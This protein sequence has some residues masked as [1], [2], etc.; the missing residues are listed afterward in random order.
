MIEIIKRVEGERHQKTQLIG[1]DCQ[2][3]YNSDGRLCVRIITNSPYYQGETPLDLDM[4]TL[5]VFDRKVS[6]A[7]KEFCQQQLTA[8]KGR[9][10]D[11]GL[12]F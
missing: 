11:D 7:V 3:S 5:I 2:I 10:E 8:S 12:P 6:R 1:D 9:K 4:D